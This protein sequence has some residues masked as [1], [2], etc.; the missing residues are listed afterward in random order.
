MVIHGG[1]DGFSR[2]FVYLHCAN[3]NK[4][5]TVLSCFRDAIKAFGFPKKIRTDRG[6]EN[7]SVA[8]LMFKVVRENSVLTGSSVHNQRVE[9]LWRDLNVAVTR[10]FASLFYQME[11][12]GILNRDNQKHLLA[13]H[14]VFIPKINATLVISGIME[15][16]QTKFY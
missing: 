16:S 1:I 6:G 14:Y 13:L 15:Q 4:T 9:R 5:Q 12:N 2:L 11:N 3:N 7:Q 10:V 8:R